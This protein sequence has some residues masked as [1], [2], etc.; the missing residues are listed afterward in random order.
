MDAGGGAECV[1]ADD[2]IVV[3]NRHAAR[4]RHRLA[5]CHQRREVAIDE[6]HHHQV[7]EQ[8]LHR[9]VANALADP[10]GGGVHAGGA[11]FE[12]GDAVDDRQVAIAVA[13]PVKADLCARCP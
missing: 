2:R 6:A 4:F 1:L 5:I 10:E 7:D 8:Q 11:G 13:V 12:R 9:R 3:G